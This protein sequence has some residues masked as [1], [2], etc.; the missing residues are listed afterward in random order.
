[1]PLWWEK[2]GLRFQC[3]ACG[4]CCGGEPGIVNA[5]LR[6]RVAIAAELKID[7][8]TLENEYMTLKEGVLT[9][10][11]LENYDCIFVERNSRRCKIYK[12]RPLQCQL[13]PFWPSML[14]N[15]DI[16]D[17][18]A[19][20]CVGMNRGKLYPPEL[21]KKFLELPSARRL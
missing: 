7:E 11:E 4:R 5:T 9:F 18:Y 2:S 21:L 17:F 3:A 8:E 10:R 15:K 14:R 12:I 1:M 16:W 6:E 13:F 19:G 20:L